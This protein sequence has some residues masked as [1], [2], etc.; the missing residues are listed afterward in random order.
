MTEYAF[1]LKLDVALRVNAETQEQAIAM[2]RDVLD[3]ADVN[4]GAWPSGDPITAEAS[5]NDVPTL[6]EVDGEPVPIDDTALRHYAAA[7][8]DGWAQGDEDTPEEYCAAF[9]PEEELAAI[10]AKDLDHY[11]DEF[12]SYTRWMEDR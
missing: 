9:V 2:L 10:D 5:M 7:R 1:D 4:L 12:A 8:N 3:C 6:Y 11:R